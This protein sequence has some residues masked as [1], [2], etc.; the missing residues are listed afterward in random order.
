MKIVYFSMQI[1]FNLKSAGDISNIIQ[2]FVCN[3]LFCFILYKIFTRAY[4]ILTN[5]PNVGSYDH[6]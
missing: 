2:H 4:C 5:V 6:P 3:L 1:I